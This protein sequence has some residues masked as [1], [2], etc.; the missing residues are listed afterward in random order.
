MKMSS[1][2]GGVFGVLGEGSKQTHM[3]HE[4]RWCPSGRL[5]ERGMCVYGEKVGTWKKWYDN[6]QVEC[7]GKYAND[8]PHGEWQFFDYFGWCQR[9]VE[10]NH[11]KVSGMDTSWRSDTR[12]GCVL[13]TQ[14]RKQYDTMHGRYE[15]WKVNHLGEMGGILLEEGTY[16]MDSKVGWWK[17]YHDN[18]NVKTLGFYVF[19]R[20]T[21]THFIQW[22][23]GGQVLSERVPKVGKD[24]V[25]SARHEVVNMWHANGTVEK[26]GVVDK[27][28]QSEGFYFHWRDTPGTPIV[29]YLELLKVQIDRQIASMCLIWKATEGCWSGVGSQ[30]QSLFSLDTDL[31]F[32]GK[33][34]SF[35]PNGNAECESTYLHG[36]KHGLET[37]WDPDGQLKHQGLFNDGHMHGLWRFF[38]NGQL[39]SECTYDE[40][41]RRGMFR[42]WTSDQHGNVAL[43]FAGPYD[44]AGFKSGVWTE[45]IQRQTD[46]GTE[47]LIEISKGQY[48]R[49]ERT[50]RWVSYVFR[51][52]GNFHEDLANGRGVLTSDGEYR[53]G[54]KHWHW[55]LLRKVDVQSGV[56]IYT[57][58][59]MTDGQQTGRWIG[60]HDNGMIAEDIWYEPNGGGQWDSDNGSTSMGWEAFPSGQV[61]KVWN[62][63]ARI[64][65][66][67]YPSGRLKTSIDYNCGTEQHPLECHMKWD[68]DGNLHKFTVKTVDGLDV[69]PRYTDMECIIMKTVPEPGQP[70]LTCGSEGKHVCI[71]EHMVRFYKTPDTSRMKCPYCQQPI[72][73]TVYCQTWF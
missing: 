22:D 16:E 15:L 61:K 11:G 57:S 54:K 25:V 36:R 31:Q 59:T 38:Q 68:E 41:D 51:Y 19:D 52:T 56:C 20:S 5:K 29:E 65:R 27:R 58:G 4:L 28:T 60:V 71:H 33:H 63:D 10:F 21:P 47:T 8:L 53:H 64:A 7:V 3:K 35:Y 24:G 44:E 32:H 42:M 49:N 45:W 9:I 26:T 37:A 1:G 23:A 39:E 62:W 72:D 67:Y 6:G 73:S 18:G 55:K 66:E 14:S 12:N 50:G 40:G 17:T 2:G 13:R 48:E 30:P 34:L 70:Y 69:E 46:E 43:C